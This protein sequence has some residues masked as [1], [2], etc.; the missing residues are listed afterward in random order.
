MRLEQGSLGA[1]GAELVA[2]DGVESGAV[3]ATA[4]AVEKIAMSATVTTVEAGKRHAR[5]QRLRSW[6]AI[7]LNGSSPRPAAFARQFDD[8]VDGACKR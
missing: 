1:A 3:C 5:Q 8:M 6:N 7:S 4:R 2:G